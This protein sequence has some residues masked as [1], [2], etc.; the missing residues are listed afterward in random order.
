MLG[1]KTYEPEELAQARKA[2][3]D[4]LKAYK[5]LAK[6]AAGDDAAAALTAFEPQFVNGL[7]MT[8]DRF[9]IHRVRPVVGKDPNPLNEVEVLTE[10]LLSGTTLKTN[11]VI[12]WVP[13]Q[14]VLG[15][16]DGDPISLTV[17]QF[18]ELAKAF[19]AELE[20]RFLTG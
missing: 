17:A 4:E 5:K 1:R 18:E 15:L 9:F 3:D 16:E 19:F 11:K 13:D 8:L 7:I 14:M 10:S 6:A 20:A 2:I 12:K